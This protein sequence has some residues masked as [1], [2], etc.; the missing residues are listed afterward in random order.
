MYIFVSFKIATFSKKNIRF[1]T[2][3]L[4][5]IESPERSI[6]GEERPASRSESTNSSFH[7][8]GSLRSSSPAGLRD[9]L[10]VAP[11]NNRDRGGPER[12]SAASR[13]RLEE[14]RRNEESRG[15]QNRATDLPPSQ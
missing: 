6:S 10:I 13:N 12:S 1:S 7:S 8:M 4:P 2:A 9:P 5:N 14:H 15:N 3:D 11:V